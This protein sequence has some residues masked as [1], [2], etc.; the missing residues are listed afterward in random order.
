MFGRLTLEFT[1]KPRGDGD[2]IGQRVCSQVASA[3]T[4][5]DGHP[6][7]ALRFHDHGVTP[8]SVAVSPTPASMQLHAL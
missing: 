1:T 6:D 4:D 3:L 2:S 5:V 8:A 7:A